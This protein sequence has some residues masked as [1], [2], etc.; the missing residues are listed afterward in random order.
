LREGRRSKGRRAE[1]RGRKRRMNDDEEREEELGK[2]KKG[3][4]VDGV[5]E[6]GK[7]M[8]GGACV[9]TSCQSSNFL[10]CRIRNYSRLAL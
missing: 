2:R 3:G 4:G 5:G 6:E 1:W 9:E 10:N 8:R 7:R